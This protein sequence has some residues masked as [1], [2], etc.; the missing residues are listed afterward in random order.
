MIFKARGAAAA[1][2]TWPIMVT[3]KEGGFS[4]MPTERIEAP[5]VFKNPANIS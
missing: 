4:W 3:T 5:V 1:P 2:T